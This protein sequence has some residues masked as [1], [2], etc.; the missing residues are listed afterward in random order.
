MQKSILE[1]FYSSAGFVPNDRNDIKPYL[2]IG[3][4][5]VHKMVLTSTAARIAPLWV[6]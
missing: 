3:L 2:H 4:P 6:R 5:V 1:M